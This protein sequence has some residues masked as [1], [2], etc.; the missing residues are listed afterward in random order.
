MLLSRGLGFVI[1]V[2]FVPEVVAGIAGRRLPGHGFV[3]LVDGTSDAPF[4]SLLVTAGGFALALGAVLL[5][6]RLGRGADRPRRLVR[7][8]RAWGADWARGLL[9]G[10]GA[11]TIAIAPLVAAGAVRI[12]GLAI[13]GAGT[14]LATAVLVSLVFKAAVEEMGFRGPAFRDLGGAIGAPLAAVF[15]AGSFA[16]LHGANPAFD[17]T[18]MLGTFT[19]GFAL[20][21]FV[22][23]RGD[24]AMAAG[25]HAGWNVAVGLVWSMPVSGY[26]LPGRLL[27]VEWSSAPAAVRWSGGDFGIEGGLAGVLALFALGFFAWRL[28]SPGDGPGASG[29][30]AGDDPS[31][32]AAAS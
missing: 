5:H 17:R 9:W 7:F 29:D 3:G 30:S 6:A 18:A 10:A 23:A 25:A 16:L 21:G 26:R 8:D 19:A 2:F 24:L 31:G 1:L 13:D 32:A 12:R 22:R 14:G 27:D 4:V 11:A 15:L 28:R 20:A